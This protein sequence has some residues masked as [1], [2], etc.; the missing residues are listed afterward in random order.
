[1]DRII[2]GR[3]GGGEEWGTEKGYRVEEVEKALGM[4]IDGDG[5][6]GGEGIVAERLNLSELVGYE[7]GGRMDMIGNNMIGFST[8][9]NECG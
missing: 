2:E 7:V 3:T 8:E 6:F 9:R 1:I 5:G 4:L